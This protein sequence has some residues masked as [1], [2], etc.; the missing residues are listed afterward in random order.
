MLPR[1]YILCDYFLTLFRPH[2]NAAMYKKVLNKD[3]CLESMNDK[4][5][6][7]IL[8][9][10]GLITIIENIRCKILTFNDLEVLES[11]NNNNNNNL[12]ESLM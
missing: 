7:S 12:F 10:N 6:T 3:G 5:T 11:N 9:Q 8:L 1:I 4:R 2:H